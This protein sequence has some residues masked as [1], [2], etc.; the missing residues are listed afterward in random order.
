MKTM[1]YCRLKVTFFLQSI[2]TISKMD[3][4][5]FENIQKTLQKKVTL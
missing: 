4:V 5:H 1:I 3:I 2:L